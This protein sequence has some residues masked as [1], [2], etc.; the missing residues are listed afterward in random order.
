MALRQAS[1]EIHHSDQGVQYACRDYVE[2]LPAGVRISMAA[3]GEAWQNGHAERVIRTIK[4]EC[5]ELEEYDDYADA[6]RRIGAFLQDVYNRKRIHSALGYR[7]PA[8]YEAAYYESRDGEE[9]PLTTAPDA[10]IIPVAGETEAGTAQ[11][12]PARD[13]R[14]GRRRDVAVGAALRGRPRFPHLGDAP[15][16]SENLVLNNSTHFTV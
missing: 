15:H 13:S 5:I 1:P 4:E 16:A 9:D 10:A 12:Q 3:V 7:T 8:E 14:L 6:R 2:A 11:E